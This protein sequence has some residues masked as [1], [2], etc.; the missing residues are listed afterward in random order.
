MNSFRSS[1]ANSFPRNCIQV[2]GSLIHV[3]NELWRIIT[4]V[5][6]VFHCLVKRL[7]FVFKILWEILADIS[8]SSEN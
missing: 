5:T 6:D 4:A 2:Q 1:S 7:N 3:A 8:S